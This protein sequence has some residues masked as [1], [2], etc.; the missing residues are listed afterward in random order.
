MFWGILTGI[1]ISILYAKLTKKPDSRKPVNGQRDAITALELE[2][3]FPVETY[4]SINS[5]LHMAYLQNNKENVQSFFLSDFIL[6]GKK[7][8]ITWFNESLF[9][10]NEKIEIKFKHLGQSNHKNSEGMGEYGSQ[11]GYYHC[12]ISMSDKNILDA[13]ARDF[14][15]SDL[16]WNYIQF[17]DMEKLIFV[18]DILGFNK[19]ISS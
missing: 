3:I 11:F 10:H 7:T 1:L 6:N 17:V 13:Q 2:R 14:D 19:N 8:N 18:T 4:N 9:F 5:Q 15:F 12:L 16:S